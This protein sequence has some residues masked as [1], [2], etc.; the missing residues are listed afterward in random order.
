[1]KVIRSAGE[2]IS[3]LSKDSPSE[4]IVSARATQFVKSL[5]VLSTK[6]YKKNYLVHLD[7]PCTLPDDRLC[8]IK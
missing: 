1:M 8:E 2:T 6:Q 7:V 4:D 5:E 3:E